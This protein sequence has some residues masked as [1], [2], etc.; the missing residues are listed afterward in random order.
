MVRRQDHDREFAILEVLLVAQVLIA[1]DQDVKPSL[2]GCIEKCSILETVPA[3]FVSHRH[4]MAPRSPRGAG[5]LTSNKILT[6]QALVVQGIAIAKRST[7][8]TCSA[9]TPG[10]HSRNSSIIEPL[11]RCSKRESTARRVPAKHH[12]PP[13]LLGFRST[14]VHNLPSS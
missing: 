7:S 11:S 14:A 1:G 8:C 4:L 5:V 12:A 2:F 3:Q 10:N 9:G 6:R 13:S